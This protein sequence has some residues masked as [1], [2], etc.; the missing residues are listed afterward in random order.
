MYM[1]ILLLYPLQLR[2]FHI[3][4]DQQVIYIRDRL[5][6]EGKFSMESCLHASKSLEVIVTTW[7]QQLV[8]E[9]Q[10]CKQNEQSKI[11]DRLIK[12]TPD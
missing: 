9:F 8:G 5:E 1:Y 11:A 6:F 7:L 10:G 4:D 3:Q 12:C 2:G